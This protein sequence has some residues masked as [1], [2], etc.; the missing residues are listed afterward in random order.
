MLKASETKILIF[1]S[2]VLDEV[3][4]A[5]EVKTPKVFGIKVAMS[6]HCFIEFIMADPIMVRFDHNPLQKFDRFGSGIVVGKPFC[7]EKIVKFP[8]R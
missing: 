1:K 6:L 3:A 5:V 8:H 4:E 7:R 2:I